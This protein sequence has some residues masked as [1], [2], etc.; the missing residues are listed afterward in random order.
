MRLSRSTG[1][2]P[3]I[4]GKQTDGIRTSVHVITVQTQE[5]FKALAASIR[6]MRDR[7]FKIPP[8]TSA[9]WA[10]LGFRE[11]DTH[12]SNIPAPEGTPAPSLSYPGGPPRPDAAPGPHAGD[13]DTGNVFFE[14]APVW[15][16][17][18][19]PAGPRLPHILV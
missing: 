17:S 6:S 19:V 1:R 8:L 18:G 3:G 12:P 13:G 16:V 2:V 10:A 14:T 9:D 15:V 5:A 11:K 4:F 7:R